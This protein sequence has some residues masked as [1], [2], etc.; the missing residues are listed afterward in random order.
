MRVY[1]HGS[2]YNQARHR[3][4]IA[5]WIARHNHPFSIVE[6][7]ELL[8]IFSDLNSACVTPK[9]R[10]VSRDIQQ[11][12]FMSRENIGALLWVCLY[13]CFLILNTDSNEYIGLSRKASHLC[14][15]MDFSQHHCLHRSHGS[16]GCGRQDGICNLRLHKV[17]STIYF[18]S[19]RSLLLN[20]T[21]LIEQRKHTLGLILP[22]ALL[23]ASMNTA[24]RIR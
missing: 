8:D 4:K 2:Q 6:D 3:M 9:R 17:R 11:I 24:F 19:Y 12:F 13:L 18:K 5:L 16:L 10:T 21:T 7:E 23:S 15:W 1:A 14:R 22:L 20:Q